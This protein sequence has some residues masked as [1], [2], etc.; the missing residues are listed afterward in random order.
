MRPGKTLFFNE[1]R[2]YL[3]SLRPPLRKDQVQRA[4]VLRATK[5]CAGRKDLR[6]QKS[7]L[8]SIVQA[9][10]G[11]H[12]KVSLRHRGCLSARPQGFLGGATKAPQI[13]AP[14]RDPSISMA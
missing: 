6:K 2:K 3:E 4:F 9:P 11:F 8:K 5:G 14:T 12:R 1:G 7:P 13:L 10:Q